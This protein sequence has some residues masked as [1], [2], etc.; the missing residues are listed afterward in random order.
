MLKE[1]W[2]FINIFFSF[3]ISLNYLFTLLNNSLNMIFRGFLSASIEDTYKYK[4]ILCNINQKLN[5]Q[6]NNFI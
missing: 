1:I 6:F 4:V 5:L 2:I 3:H